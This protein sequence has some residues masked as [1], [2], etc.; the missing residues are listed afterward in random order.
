MLGRELL[1]LRTAAGLSQAEL[2]EKSGVHPIT[3]GRIERAENEPDLATLRRLA[4]ALGVALTVSL[5]E[6][7]AAVPD[8]AVAR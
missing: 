1:R 5:G 3:I 6:P 8:K 2:G 7:S 4:S